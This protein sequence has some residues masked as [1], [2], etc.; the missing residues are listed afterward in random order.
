MKFI[1]KIY[2]LETQNKSPKTLTNNEKKRLKKLLRKS[3]K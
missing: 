1:N 3:K 2:A